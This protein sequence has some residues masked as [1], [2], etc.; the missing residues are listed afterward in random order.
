[1]VSQ[2]KA[3]VRANPRIATLNG[4]EANINVLTKYR[5]REM[6]RDP[7]TGDYLPSGTPREIETGIKV[8]I[9]PWVTASNEINLEILP[10]I[11]NKTGEIEVSA[12]G[13]ALPV[14]SKRQINTNIRVKDGETIIIGGLIQSQNTESIAQVPL[15]GRIPI[16]GYLFKQKKEEDTQTEMVIYIT[17]HLLST[18]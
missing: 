6:L 7:K 8:K 9:R 1:M 14:T 10:E 4:H 15:L 18:K 12:V 5:Y 17:P 3:K 2:G 13:G 11:S 16:L